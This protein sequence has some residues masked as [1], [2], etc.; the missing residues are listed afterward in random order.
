MQ[1]GGEELRL[2]PGGEVAAPV[3]LVEVD[4]VAHARA[5]RLASQPSSVGS[6]EKP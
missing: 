5:V 2:L 1:L 3:G 6:A 4:E